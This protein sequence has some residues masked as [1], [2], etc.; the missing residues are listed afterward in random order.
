MDSFRSS[1]KIF[2]VTYF[3]G[4]RKV[5]DQNS[6]GLCHRIL[7]NFMVRKRKDSTV[8]SVVLKNA[9]EACKIYIV[10]RRR[11]ITTSATPLS[12]GGR[13]KTLTLEC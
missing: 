10:A 1:Y 5:F 6:F 7:L 8:P 3:F 13:L 11:L 4:N 12:T 9:P 2:G